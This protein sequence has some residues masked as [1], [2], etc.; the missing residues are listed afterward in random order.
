MAHRDHPSDPDRRP[1]ADNGSGLEERVRARLTE[2]L[3]WYDARARENQ[4]WY[5]AIKVAQLLAAALVPV[6]AGAGVSAWVTGG[7]GSA[8][9][10]MEGVQQLYQFQEH[11]I[12]YR[13]TWEGLRRELYLYEAR[14]GSYAAATNPPSLLAE[15][16]EALVEREH[17]RWVSVQEAA[18]RGRSQPTE[19]TV[20]PTSGD[21]R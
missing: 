9:V 2:E 16:M 7:L 4:R 17:A 8:I 11:W 6:V 3:R 12:A 19:A 21:S 13:S 1:E 15:R 10:V 5:R 20:P 14:A 18:A